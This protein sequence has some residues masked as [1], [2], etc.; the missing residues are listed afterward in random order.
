MDRRRVNRW[1]L[2]L[3]VAAFICLLFFL[4]QPILMPFVLGALIAYLG[5][6]LVDYLERHRFN[7]STNQTREVVPS[8]SI[9]LYYPQFSSLIITLDH[10]QNL[11][12]MRQ[13]EV[14]P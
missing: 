6:P 5:D 1:P 4:L 7:R 11:K 12:E 14:Q 9:L 13:I 3:G 10:W 8:L 2:I